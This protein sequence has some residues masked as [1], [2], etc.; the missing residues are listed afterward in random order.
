M[1]VEGEKIVIDEP[2]ENEQL[3]EFMREISQQEIKEIVIENPQIDS[4][5]LQAIL[6]LKEKTIKCSDNFLNKIFENVAIEE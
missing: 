5:V 2:V 6:C 3:E 4:S 1:R